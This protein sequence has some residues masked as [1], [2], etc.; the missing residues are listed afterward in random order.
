M[1]LQPIVPDSIWHA[2]QPIK[3]GPLKITTRAT[4]VRLSDGT[5]WV[6]SPI[7][8]NAELVAGIGRI[9]PVRHVI[10]PNKWHH[11]FLLPFLAA[12]PEAD[13]YIAPGLKEKR[14]DLVAYPELWPHDAPPWSAEL[15]STF[16]E[17][18]PLL[19]ETVW[20]HRATGT[21]IVTDLLFCAGPHNTGLSRF[22]ARALGIYDRLAMSRT[23]KLLVRDKAALARCAERLL[24][25]DV[26]RII[27]AHDQV[28]DT[29]AKAKL[30]QAFAWLSPGRCPP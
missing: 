20:F 7:A 14:P 5:L 12:F 26:R 23:L 15:E 22:A 4:F 3:F 18:I 1:V 10:A 30:E 17:G 16:I 8:P 29:D 19:N 13:G 9:G 21:L 25:Q 24:A 28:I 6:H 2:Q 27:L 11:L